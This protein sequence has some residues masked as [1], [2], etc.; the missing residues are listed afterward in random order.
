MLREAAEVTIRF[1]QE[2][3]F[4]LVLEDL[5]WSDVSTLEWLS[6]IAQR[7]E[8]AKLL[9]IGTY[10]PQDVLVSSHP[11][12]GV[13]QDLTARGRC[14][15]LRVIPLSEH[16]VSEYLSRRFGS[17]AATSPLPV[18]IHRRTG[19]NP[20][21]LLNVTEYLTDQ[22]VLR[23]EEG[24][25]IVD[26]DVNAV[27]EGVPQS[28]QHLIERQLERLPEDAQRLL[29]V[30]S[31]AGAEFSAAEAATGLQ[32][33]VEVVEAQCNDLVRKG[34]FLR[35][36]GADEWPDGTLSERYSFQHALY[37]EVLYKRLAETQRVR[38]HRRIGE[39]KEAAYGERAGEIA[40]ELATHFEAGRDPKRTVHHLLQ[41]GENALQRYANHEAIG[42][43]TK[44]LG[45]LKALPNTPESLRYEL[46]L[47]IALG[48]ALIATK[49][50]AA[51]EVEQ[52]YLRARELCQ[53]L[54][55]PSVLFPAV[56]GLWNYYITRANYQPTRELAE[57]MLTLARQ[58][59]DPALL[60]QAHRALTE[61]FFWMGEFLTAREHGEQGITLYDPRQHHAHVLLYAEEPGAYCRALTAWVL[62]YLGYPEQALEKSADA[63]A[64]ARQEAH[65]FSEAMA[66]T[67]ATQLFL[68]RGEIP[69]ARTRAEEGIALAATHGFPFWETWG[70][71]LHGWALAQLGQGEEGSAQIQQALEVYPAVEF[72]TWHLA[73][74]AEASVRAGRIDEGRSVLTERWQW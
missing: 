59:H 72:L 69:A 17:F 6:Y 19:G 44:G 9:I 31:V 63:L 34:Q 57:Q 56:F 42:H 41:A 53:Q 2:R 18:L 73:L 3:G 54:E 5:H 16:A 12:R 60:L 4:V 25:W 51:S 45:F 24:Q 58:H 11:L 67:L 68:L 32:V 36:L 48:P 10:R 39:R 26:G 27:A 52:A 7:R 47:R 38:L 43:L 30:A 61:T 20:L 70:I 40:A 65:P 21:F 23:Q 55:D 22:N 35:A 13:V 8:P 71:I 74:L 33:E 37:H 15:E 64:L 1:T 14:E 28:L 66:L 62:W 49:G 46:S 50:Y 29:E